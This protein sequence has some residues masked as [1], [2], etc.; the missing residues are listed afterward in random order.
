MILVHRFR[1]SKPKSEQKGTSRTSRTSD[2]FGLGQPSH[3][4]SWI[5][6]CANAHVGSAMPYTS[7]TG[8]GCTL[9]KMVKMVKF[10]T[11]KTCK[12]MQKL[13]RSAES[14]G[15]KLCCRT[16][17]PRWSPDLHVGLGSSDVIGCHRM[18]SSLVITEIDLENFIAPAW[19]SITLPLSLSI[20]V[21]TSLC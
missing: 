6:A 2:H 5:F 17:P 21:L 10:Q 15:M 4:P 12:N 20:A 11:N 13:L 16:T 14:S 18:S 7:Y 1:G 3:L 9:V 8:W 19:P